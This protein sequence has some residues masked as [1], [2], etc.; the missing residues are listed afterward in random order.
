MN[1]FIPCP[2]YDDEYISEYAQA[3]EDEIDKIKK[4]LIYSDEQWVGVLADYMQAAK[5]GDIDNEIIECL[6]T[7]IDHALTSPFCYR[8][9]PINRIIADAFSWKAEQIAKE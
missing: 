1:P 5:G 7:I 3:H 4:E 6:F 8:H 9:S 2:V